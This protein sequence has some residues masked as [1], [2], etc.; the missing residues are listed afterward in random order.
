MLVLFAIWLASSF[1]KEGLRLLRGLLPYGGGEANAPL[2]P[3][4]FPK[5]FSAAMKNF[6]QFYTKKPDSFYCR[7]CKCYL[8]FVSP[9]DCLEHYMAHLRF[10]ESLIKDI[11]PL[12]HH[13]DE[14][15]LPLT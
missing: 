4:L 12:T 5:R 10:V 3:F 13:P 8:S 1:L 11:T 9:D 15:P 14:V 2:F 7:E 6:M